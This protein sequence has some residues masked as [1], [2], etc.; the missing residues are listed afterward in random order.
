MAV[1]VFYKI[2]SDKQK[3]GKDSP[4]VRQKPNKRGYFLFQE[5]QK[6]VRFSGNYSDN[7]EVLDAEEYSTVAES[8]GVPFITSEIYSDGVS[9]YLAA[10]VVVAQGGLD[11]IPSNTMYLQG[12]WKLAGDEKVIVMVNNNLYGKIVDDYTFAGMVK[13]EFVE[14]SQGHTIIAVQETEISKLYIYVL[15]NFDAWVEVNKK[16]M[17]CDAARNEKVFA[18]VIVE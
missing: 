1:G 12:D 8:A 14:V 15:D 16:G 3:N 10:E 9:I 18:E 7:A 5:V 13:L 2:T 17:D 6:E 11:N 4:F